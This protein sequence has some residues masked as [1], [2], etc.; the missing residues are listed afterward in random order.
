[1][2]DVAPFFSFIF[3]FFKSNRIHGHVRGGYV[4]QILLGKTKADVERES[5]TKCKICRVF[6]RQGGRKLEEVETVSAS[7]R[8]GRNSVRKSTERR[9]QREQLEGKAETG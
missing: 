2:G 5:N 9:R 4:Q 7:Q 1:M 3:T 8:R 6:V